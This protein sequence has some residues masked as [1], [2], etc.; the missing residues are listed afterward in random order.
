[1]SGY[2]LARA[3]VRIGRSLKFPGCRTAFLILNSLI[4]EGVKGELEVLRQ[5][6][7]EGEWVDGTSMPRQNLP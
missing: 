3:V 2:G 5:L 6:G 7:V 1:V 4:N